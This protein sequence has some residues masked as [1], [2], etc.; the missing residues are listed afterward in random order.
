MVWVRGV[1]RQGSGK[2]S[3][4]RVQDTR[5]WQTYTEREVKRK[6]NTPK[7]SGSKRKPWTRSEVSDCNVISDCSMYAAVQPKLQRGVLTVLN[8]AHHDTPSRQKQNTTHGP[9]KDG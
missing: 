4:C 2:P 6:G 5:E 1:N 9:P 3:A 7:I 8:G